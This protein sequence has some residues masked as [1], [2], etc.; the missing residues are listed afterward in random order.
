M[1]VQPEPRR[2][3][4]VPVVFIVVTF[5]VLVAL[6]TWQ[7][8]RKS[9]KEGLIA[10]LNDKLSAQPVAMPPHEKWTELS[11][12]ADEFRRVK[13]SAEFLDQEALVYTSG[14]SIR[15]DV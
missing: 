15:P 3:I 11:P 13:F 6:G 12:E 14:S 5:A 2:G 7:L 4:V 10:Q 1:S 8:E 9:W